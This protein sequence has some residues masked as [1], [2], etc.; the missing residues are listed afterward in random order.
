MDTLI[1]RH[2]LAFFAVAMALACLL[3]TVYV[4]LAQDVM[5][6][7]SWL[8]GSPDTAVARS[9]APSLEYLQSCYQSKKEMSD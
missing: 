5:P 3:T 9:A 2:P 6:D 1:E 4:A 8:A 7:L